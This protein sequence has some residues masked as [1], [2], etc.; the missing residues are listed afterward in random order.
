MKYID[1][2]THSSYTGGKHTPAELLKLAKEN[3]ISVLSL[4][5]HNVID[6]VPE[7]IEESTKYGIT[8]I[9][10]VEIYTRFKNKNLH[11]L[12]YGFSIDDTPLRSALKNL[13]EDN[14]EQIK[15]TISV[16]KKDGIIIDEDRIF[17][18]PERNRGVLHILAE[19]EQHKENIDA[20][21]KA[22]PTD[23]QDFF[24]KVDYYFGSDKAAH[25]NLSE[26][27]T[28]DGIKFIKDSGG[29]AVLAHPGQQ[30]N[31]EGDQI[32][33]ELIKLGLQGIEVLSPYHTW[34]Q[35][36]HYQNFALNNNLIMT[37]GSDYH[38]DIDFTKQEII[39]RQ[40]DYFKAPYSLYEKLQLI[41]NV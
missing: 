37:G 38:S 1:L 36:E 5:D 21:N 32:I 22:I 9:S 24:A 4:T 33:K 6:G 31:Y 34:H 40:W 13:Q 17:S 25:F 39:A 18:G 41:I 7:L 12:G 35:I 20:L 29:A 11:L 30:L 15:K 16:L 19:I 10:G 2:H 14:V 3:G 26:I 27:P 23:K 8:A 28:E